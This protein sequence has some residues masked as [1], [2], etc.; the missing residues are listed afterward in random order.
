MDLGW[1]AENREYLQGLMLDHLWLSVLPLLAAV[2]IAVPLGWVAHRYRWARGPLLSSSVVLYTI[3]S[4]AMFTIVPSLLGTGILDPLNVVVGL[5]IYAV[6]LLVRTSADAF[7]SVP[8]DVLDAASAS[9]YGPV[10]R[11]LAVELPLAGPVLLAG[12]RVASVSTVSLVSVGVLIG[13]SSLGTL[14]TS[15]LRREFPTEILTG[16]AGTLLIALAL[17]ALL[18]LAGRLLMPWSRA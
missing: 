11:A 13:V 12:L 15:G 9:G 10:R 18:V 1:I 7:A 17:D 4:F 2:A 3:P 5:A 6:A 16:V 14:F 8:A